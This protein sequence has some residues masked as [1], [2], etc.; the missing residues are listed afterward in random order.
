MRYKLPKKVSVILQWALLLLAPIA[1]L[2][3]LECYTHNPFQTMSPQ[4]HGLNILFFELAMLLLLFLTGRG[5]AALPILT[6][7][8]AAAGLANYF[9]LLFRS[10]PIMPWDI[11]SIRTA[12]SVADNFQYTLDK[13]AALTL[14]GFLLLLILEF[15]CGI[16]LKKNLKLKLAG[17][18]LSFLCLFGFTKMLH[19][20]GA[21]RY[22]KLYDKLFTPTTMQRKDGTVVAFLMELRYLSVSK[23]AGYSDDRAEELLETYRSE[24][25]PANTPNII[26]IMDEAFSDLSILGEFGVN[27][28][29]MPFIHSLLDGAP[30]TVSGNLNVSV[31]GGN[32]ANTEFEFLTGNSMAFLPQG[33]IPYQQYIKGELP[34]MASYLKSFGYET[35][36]MHPYHASGWERDQVYPWFGFDR[37]YFLDDFTDAEYIRKYVSDQSNF[38][39]IIDVYEKKEKDRPLF[40]FNV[41]MQ[42]HS[43]YS[44]DYDNFHP[45]ITLTDINSHALENYLSLIRLTDGAVEDLVS[46][47]EKQ[48]EDTMIVFFGDHQPT[49]FIADPILRTYGKTSDSLSEEEQGLRYTVPYFIWSNFD[50]EGASGQDTSSNYLGSRTLKLAGIPLDP[51]SA[52]LDELRNR[53]PVITSIKVTDGT[54]ASY[55]VKQKL[56]ELSEYETLQ[57]Y[58]LFGNR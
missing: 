4:A 40:L 8:T 52:F 47:F 44:E 57:Y 31:L 41:T 1:N 30:N 5:R 39:K 48:E 24:D 28:D 7:L 49:N 29:Y 2:Y 50:M 16:T 17:F 53:F 15:F 56:T 10:A 6:L 54:G 18:L 58:M 20:D 43:S 38:D 19:Q 21:V 14:A 45:D 23:P 22:F 12:A 13:R 3:L 55:P 9:V 36:A 46:Y 25:T 32:T 37:T 33:S 35:V 27:M 11:Y 34:T 26:V 42:N 51:Y